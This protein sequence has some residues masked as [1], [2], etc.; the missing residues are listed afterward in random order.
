MTSA[1]VKRRNYLFPLLHVIVASKLFVHVLTPLF[2]L[3][4]PLSSAPQDSS[5]FIHV[6]I[7]P[8]SSLGRHNR[9]TFHE[10]SNA[11]KLQL[12]FSQEIDGTHLT[13]RGQTK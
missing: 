1:T 10:T 12:C 11:L 8:V 2:C 3:P 4:V 5:T 6:L 7:C 13:K 9:A